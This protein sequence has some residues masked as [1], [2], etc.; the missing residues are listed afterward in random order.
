MALPARIVAV[1][2]FV[3]TVG[4]AVPVTLGA[5][6][7]HRNGNGSFGSA[8]RA[9]LFVASLLYLVGIVVVWSIAGGGSLWGVA[10]TLL[11][12]GFVALIVL[13]VVPLLV[14]Q[15]VIRRARHVDSETALRFATY[16]WPIAMFA[17]FGIFVAYRGLTH[18]PFHPGSAQICVINRCTGITVSL[19]ATVLFELVVAVLGPAITGLALSSS[20]TTPEDLDSV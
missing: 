9:A 17:V 8:L 14:G 11:V 4:I 20:S 13:M 16:G 12:A 5:H 6:L 2:V 7:S 15:H 19:A 18:D 3:L 10:A 1:F